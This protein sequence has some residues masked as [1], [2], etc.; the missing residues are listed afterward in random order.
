MYIFVF[1]LTPSVENAF[2][3]VSCQ[4]PTS[5]FIHCSTHTDITN[6]LFEAVLLCLKKLPSGRW[7]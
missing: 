4:F 5:L 1:Q 2:S 6:Q 7:W 3:Y